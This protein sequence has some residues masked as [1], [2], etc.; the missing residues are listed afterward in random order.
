MKLTATYP[1]L[2]KPI[3]G[4]R[5]GCVLSS[6]LFNIYSEWII[7]EATDNWED[8]VPLIGRKKSNLWYAND[9]ALLAITKKKKK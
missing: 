6:L 7:R 1:D 9:T 8:E 2:F 3:K 4:V 5:Q